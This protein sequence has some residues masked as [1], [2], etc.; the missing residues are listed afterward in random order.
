QF[1]KTSIVI[2]PPIKINSE[3]YINKENKVITVSRFSPNK[4]LDFAFDVMKN[5]PYDW[6]LIASITSKSEYLLYKKLLGENKQYAKKNI[7]LN[8]DSK[9][10]ESILSQ[11]KVYFH[12]SPETFGLSVVEAISNGCIPIVPN[13]SAHLET[14]PFTELR[15]NSKSEAIRLINDA[16]NGKFDYLQQSLIENLIKFSEKN[17]IDKILNIMKI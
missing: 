2:Y 13:N 1:N 6:D 17:F 9:S 4:K 11:Y 14:V 16:M 7:Y 5:L 10:I 8:I 12:A 3:H 15:F